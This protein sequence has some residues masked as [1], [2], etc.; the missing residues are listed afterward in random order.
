[1]RSIQRL[2]LAFGV[3][4][5]IVFVITN[6]PAFNDAQGRNFG[7]FVI[8]P[9]DNIVHLLTAILGVLAG[10]CSPRWSRWF[11]AFFGILYGADAAVGMFLQRGLLDFSV[12]TQPGGTPDFGLTNWLLNI[13]HIGIAVVMVWLGFAFEKDISIELSMRA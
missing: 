10:W 6:V 7:L 2:A 4:F 13:P 12:F 3:L 5:L 1:M 8:N 9:I 11:L